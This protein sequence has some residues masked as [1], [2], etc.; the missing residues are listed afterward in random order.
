MNAKI[1]VFQ[2]KSTTQKRAN[3]QK[4]IFVLLE[5]VCLS[6]FHSNTRHKTQAKRTVCIE[7]K[8][9]REEW[10]GK[11]A[12]VSMSESRQTEREHIYTRH[13]I[14]VD[15]LQFNAWLMYV[16]TLALCAPKTC[17]CICVSVQGNET[18]IQTTRRCNIAKPE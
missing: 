6:V 2:M 10:D 4:K 12:R 18:S 17:V 3:R 5:C 8:K 11:C 13:C 9:K 15:T 16:Y 14:A 7:R 1:F